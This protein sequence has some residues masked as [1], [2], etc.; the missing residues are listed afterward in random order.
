MTPLLLAVGLFAVFWLLGFAFLG[1]V[2]ADTSSLR[3]TLTAPA[4]GSCVL[5]LPE[6]VLSHAGFAAEHVALPLLLVLLVTAVSIL[7]LRRPPMPVAMVPVLVVCGIGLV[8]A[9]S[10]MREFGFH[11]VANANDDMGNYTLS[12]QQLL[13]HGLL[14]SIDT[15]GLAL[16]KDY[17]TTLTGLHLLGSR[18][19]SDMMLSLVSAI[20]GRLPYEV[21]MPVAFALNLCGACG[22]G[23]LAMQA[24]RRWWAASLA[25]LLL[26][27]SPLATFGVLQQLIAQ[28]WGLALGIAL[29]ALLM[30]A[31][32]HRRPA[33]LAADAIPIGI[34][35][36]GLVIVYVELASALAVAYVLYVAI[37][38][39][40][41]ELSVRA[42]ALLSLFV[43][44]VAFVVLNTYLPTELTYVHTQASGG[45]SGETGVPLFGFTLVPA[46]LPG[47]FGLQE[48]RALPFAP[49]LSLSIATAGVLLVGTLVCAVVSARRGVAAAVG[50]LT[51]AALA[52]VLAVNN[53]TFGMYK[54]FMYVQPFLAALVAVW[55]ASVR[56]RALWVV[57]I[58]VLVVVVAQLSTQHAYV[59]RSR[60]PVELPHA[61]ASG[62]LPA[63]H[64]VA[65]RARGPIIAESENPTLI[66]LEAEIDRGKPIFFLGQEAFRGLLS[67]PLSGRDLTN[68]RR[69]QR[70]Y[71]W[72]PHSFELDS[73]T[74]PPA[75]QFGEDV[76]ASERL[77]LQSCELVMPS[78]SEVVF[79]RRS[80]PEG[81]PGLKSMPCDAAHNLVAFVSSKLGE[82]F[83]L[84]AERKNVSFYQLED[85]YFYSGR[86]FA[87]FG[88]YVLLRVLGPSRNAR[89][90]LDLTETLR[91]NGTNRLPPAAVV[92]STRVD[93]PIVGRGSARVFSRPL[94]YQIIAGVPYILLDLGANGELSEPR[95]AG[96]EGLYGRSEIV[97]PRFLTA[98]V[99]NVSL[100]DEAEYAQLNAPL[101]LS[102]FPADLANED[103]EYSGIYE[104]GW[105]GEDS[106][107]VLAHG[108]AADLVLNAA[109]PAGAGKHLQILLNGRAI[110]SVPAPAGS[111][112]VRVHVPASSSRRRVELRFAA[113]IRLKAPDLR[114]ASAHLT[115]LGLVAPN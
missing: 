96:L 4:L 7:A 109:V 78:G 13:H 104:D 24:S 110:A 6:F 36:T 65:A 83:Y 32:L 58:P 53:S 71:E 59:Q 8:L 15:K 41:R 10:P 34:L 93:L 31:E 68:E 75:D 18:P 11:W 114:P 111:L 69:A 88:R 70:A 51:F 95:R 82:G 49:H 64:V 72:A 19:G 100:V 73:S 48:L 77:T 81:S 105:V 39:L 2:H 44:A 1:V 46:G 54:L 79:N 84:P 38:A 108:P 61:S 63:F 52:A 3:V 12:A 22:A 16:G 35:V 37:L 86:T 60:D 43:A 42:L 98:Y 30:R 74:G 55:V 97:D 5:L 40:R 103:L 62:L 101:A 45:V 107:A 14:A 67:V 26:V 29:F 56:P 87:G 23:A 25:A 27:I 17:A 102:S 106:Y 76:P 9:A 89:L 20:T 66:K 99:R 47:L 57:A 33:K 112:S 94:R 90:E 115:F 21:F 113:A 92:G 91:H 85:D 80:L 28:V 50:L